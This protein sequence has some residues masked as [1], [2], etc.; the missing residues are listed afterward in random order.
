MILA[1]W[2]IHST[3]RKVNPSVICYR[4]IQ[5]LLETSIDRFPPGKLFVKRSVCM[6]TGSVSSWLERLTILLIYRWSVSFL[7]FAGPMGVEYSLWSFASR[8]LQYYLSNAG[9]FS[10]FHLK[11]V[12]F[13]LSVSN[14]GALNGNENENTIL[15]NLQRSEINLI[16]HFYKTVNKT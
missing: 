1:K 13:T 6:Y 2:I 3:S 16:F 8:R 10:S 14:T 4:A 11:R 12:K 9:F 5:S 15:W 7:C